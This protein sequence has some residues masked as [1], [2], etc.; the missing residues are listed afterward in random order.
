MLLALAMV[1]SYVEAMIPIN[2]GVPGVKLEIGRAH[3]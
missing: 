2:I 1:L 3:V